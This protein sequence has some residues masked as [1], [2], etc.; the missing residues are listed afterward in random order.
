MAKVLT[1]VISFKVSLFQKE[2]LEN[3]AAEQTRRLGREVTQ[4]MVLRAL[5]QKQMDVDDELDRVWDETIQVSGT[6]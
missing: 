6:F 5:L 3:K 2:W 1:E 4:T